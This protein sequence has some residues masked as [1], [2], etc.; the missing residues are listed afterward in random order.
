MESAAPPGCIKVS[1][2]PAEQLLVM[3]DEGL[4]DCLTEAFLPAEFDSRD[5]DVRER[6]SILLQAVRDWERAA[7]PVCAELIQ[8]PVG[9]PRARPR[10][11]T[12]LE[13]A[14]AHVSVL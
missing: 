5:Q 3:R 1:T 6:R 14:L 8:H 2:S 9:R 13:A 7:K 4:R 12:A 11:G 10:V